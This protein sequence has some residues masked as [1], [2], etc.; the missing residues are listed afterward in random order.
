M[1]GPIEPG[2]HGV[3]VDPE[4]IGLAEHDHVVPAPKVVVA[5]DG[6]VLED[7]EEGLGFAFD[8]SGVLS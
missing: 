1:V 8:T 4:R 6:S 2:L 5:P 7:V 3:D